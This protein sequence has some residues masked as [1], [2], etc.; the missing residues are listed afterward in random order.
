MFEKIHL[1]AG[2]ADIVYLVEVHLKNTD[3]AEKVSSNFPFC[4]RLKISVSHY[5]DYMTNTE[6]KQDYPTK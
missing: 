3:E 2:N 1:T 5:S 4:V 6:L